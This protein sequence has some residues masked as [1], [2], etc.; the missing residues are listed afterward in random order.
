MPRILI[1]NRGHAADG[2][3]LRRGEGT[4]RGQGPGGESGLNTFQVQQ[5]QPLP[6][7]C[8]LPPEHIAR[9]HFHLVPTTPSRAARGRV[10]ARHPNPARDLGPH[11]QSQTASPTSG[12][13]WP[14]LGSRQKPYTASTGTG[15]IFQG[16][17]QQAEKGRAE[18]TRSVLGQAPQVRVPRCSSVNEMSSLLL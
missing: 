9:A 4:G 11:P 1:A 8:C 15:L 12:H 2:R 18:V 13:P 7:P 3:S 17:P 14:W 10:P 5:V 6:T 16:S